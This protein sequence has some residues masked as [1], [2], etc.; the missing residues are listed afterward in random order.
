M[1]SDRGEERR[2]LHQPGSSD[3]HLRRHALR[4]SCSLSSLRGNRNDKYQVSSIEDLS[5]CLR[6]NST[7]IKYNWEYKS[8]KVYSSRGE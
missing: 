3:L 4:S 8:L 5:Q 2:R 1:A 7:G 6:A